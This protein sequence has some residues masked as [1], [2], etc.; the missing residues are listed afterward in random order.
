MTLVLLK[1]FLIF[2]V[3]NT[4]KLVFQVMF[5]LTCAWLRPGRRPARIPAGIQ[6]AAFQQLQGLGKANLAAVQPGV[7]QSRLR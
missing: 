7:S 5:F 6:E 3:F 4:L 2:K 1:V